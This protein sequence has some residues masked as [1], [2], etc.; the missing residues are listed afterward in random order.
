LYLASRHSTQF[1]LY[2]QPTENTQGI[3]ASVQE[4]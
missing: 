3:N 1:S 2:T 4:E